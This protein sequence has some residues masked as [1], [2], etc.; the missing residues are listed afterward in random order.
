MPDTVKHGICL[1]REFHSTDGLDNGTNKMLE[2]LRDTASLTLSKNDW[3]DVER[4][5]FIMVLLRSACQIGR[6][7]K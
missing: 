6:S 2:S 3:S 5:N 4:E 7:N 1:L